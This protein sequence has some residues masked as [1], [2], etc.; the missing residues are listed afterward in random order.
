M[1][2]KQVVFQQMA[3]CRG[4]ICAMLDVQF[5]GE[6]AAFKVGVERMLN[7]GY[8]I[9]SVLRNDSEYAIDWYDNDMHQAVQDVTNQFISSKKG[10]GM[11]AADQGVNQGIQQVNGRNYTSEQ[12]LDQIL[13][14]PGIREQ[15]DE[16]SFNL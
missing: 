3:E 12:L 5:D 13:S 15:L 16:Q 2:V 4:E 10:L 6:S 14:F 11:T 9:R 8:Q 1:E 7:G